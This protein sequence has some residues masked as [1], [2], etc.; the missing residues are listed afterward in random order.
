MHKLKHYVTGLAL[1][2]PFFSK[3]VEAQRQ[4]K[5]S[6]AEE[7]GFDSLGAGSWS[8]PL[9]SGSPVIWGGSSSE[10][11]LSEHLSQTPPASG[12]ETPSQA[13]LSH[14]EESIHGPLVSWCLLPDPWDPPRC[15]HGWL[16]GCSV[17]TG[18][19]A[20]LL[21]TPL[22]PPSSRAYVSGITLSQYHFPKT[23]SVR[24]EHEGRAVPLGIF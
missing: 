4:G 3:D 2:V 1:A 19:L 7:L 8:V 16:G 9:Q 20:H 23:R 17:L 15:P 12:L 5:L 18:W 6:R 11:A 13:Q 21:P 24:S 10:W 14:W 22:C